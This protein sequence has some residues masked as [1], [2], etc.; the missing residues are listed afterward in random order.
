MKKRFLGLTLSLIILASAVLILVP[1]KPL[2]AQPLEAQEQGDT[3]KIIEV[4]QPRQLTTSPKFD[5]NPSFFKANDGT[6]WVFFARGR[7]DPSSPGYNP[8]TDFYDV[9]YV[10]STD[11]GLTW[12]E[13]DLL[14]IPDGHGMGAFT[15]AALQ[16][17]SGKI[18]VFYAANGVGIFYFASTDNGATWTGPTLVPNVYGYTVDNHMDAI[19]ANDGSIWIFFT[20]YPD[21]AL[22]A[23]KYDGNS[24][25][26]LIFVADPLSYTATPRALQEDSGTF[27]V[28]FIAGD[29]LQIYLANSTDGIIWYNYPI[30]NTPYDDYDPVLV[31][32]DSIWRLFF[33]PYIPADDHQWLM[34]IN[35]TDL[36]TWSNPV[37]V[38]AGSYGANKW[39]DFWP[40]A[41][42]VGSDLLLFYASMKDG[43]QRGDGEIYFYK[44]NWDLIHNHYEAIYPAI[45]AASSGDTILIHDGVYDE[46]VV[47]SK[48]LTLQGMGDAT[49]VKPSS[50]DKLTTVLSGHFWGGTKQ[51]AGIIV[52]NVSTGGS[53]TV[54]NLNVDGEGV[55]TKPSGADYVAGIF[56]RETGGTIES[57]TVAN[58]IIGSTGT[59]VR[60]YGIYLSAIT[61]TVSVEVKESILTNFDKNGIDVHGSKLEVN[62]HHNTITGRGPLPSGDEVQNGVVVMD[63]AA[64][65]INSNTISNMTYAPE[66]WWAA[67]ILFYDSSGSA[68]DNII[69]ECQIGIIFNNG[70]GLAQNNTVTAGSVGLLGIWAQYDKEGTWTATFVNNTISG[71]QDSPGYENAATGAQ[72]WNEGA[73]ITL[74]IHDNQIIGDET[75]SADGIYIGDIPEY[76]PAGNI[77]AIITDNFISGW[78]HGI[79]L[80]SSV[81]EATITG[82]TIKNNLAADSGIHIEP[83]VTV[84]NIHVNYNNIF[85]NNATGAYG[86]SNNGVGTLDAR[87]NWW[88]H[89][90]GPYHPELNPSGRGDNVSNN[91]AFEP[92]LIEPYP[93]PTVVETLLYVDPANVEYWTVSFGKT[94]T[95]DVKIADVTNLHACEFKLYWNTA[96]LDLVGVQI[97]PPWSAYSIAKNETNEDLGRYWLS[98]TSLGTSTFNGSTTLV[99]ITF[100]ITFDPIYPENRTCTLDLS[101]TKLSALEGVPIYHMTHDGKY[102][103]Y[104]TKPKII[105]E[106]PT[107]TA[108]A[109]NEIFT[110]NITVQ[111]VVDLYNFSIQLSY[112]TTLLDAISLEI[113]PFI[114]KP[115]YTY[116][117]IIDDANGL[118]WL[119]VWSVSPAPPASGSGVL[120]RMTFKVT[121]AT[122]ATKIH[123]NILECALD[124]HDTLLVTNTGVEVEHD[125]EDGLYR[126]APKLGDLDMDGHVGLTDLRILAYYYDP[127]YNPIADLNED[128]KVDVYDLSILATHY[129]E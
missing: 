105:V 45:D 119:W 117:F 51:I 80:V 90:T 7:G 12:T 3:P 100:K 19:K 91:V 116:K 60:G 85:E 10:K 55:I 93:P 84:V 63:G 89:P 79:R 37:Y 103:I 99:K 118:V 65:T 73:V 50:A 40:E 48:S 112:N 34:T 72:C 38:T 86:I 78:Q 128:G 22:Y 6:W 44:V 35:S 124:L 109:I 77:T 64:G 21:N 98:M 13:G 126:Y 11:G 27:R 18:W 53:I 97:T 129:G 114:N 30:V 62:I 83:A 59:A 102:T 24:W 4:S 14:V 96:L 26:S 20:C 32:D 25:S 52:A 8:D 75:T 88:G 81:T 94:F 61:N 36:Y 66:T 54:K 71:A 108:H 104:S 101:D 9:C 15:P 110:I 82:N 76:E 67:G 29:P 28:V 106:P 113:G 111:N 121:K 57:V 33:A 69:T 123:Q 47:I 5:R 46:Q 58:I 92:W 49:I 87:Y 120:A 74:T 68:S 127:S 125:V 16:D 39:W 23:R 107:Y 1:S 70:N 31:K 41:L 2:E 115:T 42:K 17:D 95:V 122:I 43:T 56:Y